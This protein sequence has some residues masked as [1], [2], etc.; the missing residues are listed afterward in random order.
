[1]SIPVFASRSPHP[2]GVEMLHSPVLGHSKGIWSAA[3]EGLHW[4][5]VKALYCSTWGYEVEQKRSPALTEC[6]YYR[7]AGTIEIPSLG[8]ANKL[9]IN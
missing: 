6:M 9:L 8:W 5:D 7:A 4:A 2:N 1:M 3:N